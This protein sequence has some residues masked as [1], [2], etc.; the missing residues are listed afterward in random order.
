MY[1]KTKGRSS[2][3]VERSVMSTNQPTD[4]NAGRTKLSLERYARIM[5]SRP[6]STLQPRRNGKKLNNRKAQKPKAFTDRSKSDLGT[7]Y[8]P[9]K[10]SRI[11]IA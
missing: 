4:A 10:M 3:R 5:F 8:T 7:Y 2:K 6:A 11:N 9:V 1:P